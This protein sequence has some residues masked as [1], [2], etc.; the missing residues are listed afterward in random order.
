MPYIMMITYTYIDRCIECDAESFDVDNISAD[1]SYICIWILI[2]RSLP[3]LS[4]SIAMESSE[5]M[6]VESLFLIMAL[7]LAYS[8]VQSEGYL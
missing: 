3:A 1:V 5:G 6:E 7:L 4:L 8:T 2:L